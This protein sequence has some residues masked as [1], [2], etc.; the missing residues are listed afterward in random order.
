MKK[1]LLLGV[2]TLLSITISSIPSYGKSSTNVSGIS[3]DSALKIKG[4]VIGMKAHIQIFEYNTV[5]SKWSSVY[6]K[7][8]RGKYKLFLNPTKHYQIWFSHSSGVT[9]ILHVDAGDPGPWFMYL[10]IDLK[11]CNG[12]EHARVFQDPVSYD[13]DFEVVSSDYNS[14]SPNPRSYAYK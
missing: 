12:C 1:Y 7:E 11:N 4:D 14:V 8:N 3:E 6:D 2:I 9:K 5:D 13:M 10:D